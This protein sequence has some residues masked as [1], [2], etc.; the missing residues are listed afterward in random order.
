[1]EKVPRPQRLVK[2]KPPL[3]LEIPEASWKKFPGGFPLLIRFL[4]FLRF[5]VFV[6]VLLCFVKT[7]FASRELLPS[8]IRL[9][10]NVC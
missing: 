3:H 6:F 5:A 1:M 2:L 4:C 10:T 7:H 8:L 9:G